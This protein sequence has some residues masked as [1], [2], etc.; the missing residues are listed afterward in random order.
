MNPSP[1]R[2]MSTDPISNLPPYTRYITTHDSN[3]K[4]IVDTTFDIHT[5]K[6]TFPG[7]STFHLDY[8]TT[9]VPHSFAANT[10]LISYKSDA[11]NKAKLPP[12]Y[13]TP[14]GTVMQHSET[15]PLGLS[16]LHRT[17]TLDYMV[18][19]E[20]EIE[21]ILDS[22]ETRRCKRGD[23]VIQRGTMHAWRNPSST[24]WCRML[25]VLTPAEELEVGGETLR[26]EF[27]GKPDAQ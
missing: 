1:Q 6:S 3:G 23:T 27:R 21:L 12:A 20:G 4:A 2:N 26:E 14:G 22:G 9:R 17:T 5:P 15:P 11:D 10:D 8:S 25:F 18:V 13:R 16:P 19:L 24:E 7:G